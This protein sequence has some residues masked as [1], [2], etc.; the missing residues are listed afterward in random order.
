MDIYL[1]FC[2]NGYLNLKDKKDLNFTK[3]CF[4]ISSALALKHYNNINLVCDSD[5][6]DFIK[7]HASN[8]TNVFL[9]LN[10]VKKTYMLNTWSLGKLQAYNFIAKKGK[11]FIHIDYDFFLLNKLNCLENYDVFALNYECGEFYPYNDF[12]S[13]CKNIYACEYGRKYD[14]VP[15]MGIFGGKNLDFIDKYSSE[16]LSMVYNINNKNYFLESNS[17]TEFWEK[18]VMAEQ[19]YLEA[20]SRKYNQKINTLFNEKLLCSYS[21]K[22]LNLEAAELGVVH[23]QGLKEKIKNADQVF[24]NNLHQKLVYDV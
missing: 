18:A 3:E 13:K 15:N 23:L 19:F 20:C 22:A 8:W 10:N 4:K 1:S 12:Y 7:P 14:F 24:W 11:P 21:W 6:F 16:A 5:F 17:K 9:E 2:S